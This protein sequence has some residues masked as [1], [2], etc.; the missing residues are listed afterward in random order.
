MYKVVLLT[1]D[2][3]GHRHVENTSDVS[4]WPLLRYVFL[5]FHTDAR[6]REGGGGGK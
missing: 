5:S 6:E 2:Y 3:H 1:I 4:T